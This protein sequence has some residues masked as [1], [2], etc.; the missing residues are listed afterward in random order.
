MPI[1][2]SIFA[3]ID[4]QAARSSVSYDDLRVVV[5]NGTT[6]RSPEP[7]HLHWE[8]PLGGVHHEPLA[9]DE[10][11]HLTGVDE[12]PAEERCDKRDDRKRPGRLPLDCLDV[13]VPG[14]RVIGVTRIGG[15]L[16]ARQGD[17]N[18]ALH[19]DG[20]ALPH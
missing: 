9:G 11:C 12:A 3:F 19:V 5:F 20:H 2:D 18:Q 7:S 13:L 15:N 16:T 1:P 17:L 6:K 14:S 4:A 8:W 10:P